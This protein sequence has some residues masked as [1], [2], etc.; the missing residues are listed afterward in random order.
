MKNTIRTS[1]FHFHR[2]WTSEKWS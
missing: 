1:I 2:K